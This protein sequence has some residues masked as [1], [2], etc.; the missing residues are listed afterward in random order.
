MVE[1]AHPVSKAKLDVIVIAVSQKF[2]VNG[3]NFFSGMYSSTCTRS[4][5][6]RWPSYCCANF[7][8]WSRRTEHVGASNLQ[9]RA[10]LLPGSP[11]EKVCR[12]PTQPR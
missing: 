6:A 1:C 9:E 5:Q 4:F 10:G 12:A 3:L 2:L 11:A 8:Q 7:L